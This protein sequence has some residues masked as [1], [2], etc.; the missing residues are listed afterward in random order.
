MSDTSTIFHVQLSWTNRLL[1]MSVPISVYP[2][3]R[4]HI[5]NG[6]PVAAGHHLMQTL[7]TDICDPTLPQIHR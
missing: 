3:A 4:I 2:I 7:L 5:G 6:I 1:R